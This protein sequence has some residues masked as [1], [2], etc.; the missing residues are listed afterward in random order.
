[1]DCPTNGTWTVS[2]E[3]N[4]LIYNSS[5][6]TYSITFVPQT[7]YNRVGIGRIGFLLKAKDGTGNK[8]SQDFTN[9]VGVFQVNLT[10]PLQNSTSILTSGA[11]RSITAT[12]TNGLANYVLK[13][14]GTT[15]NSATGVSSYNYN[16]TNITSNQY[17]ALEVTQGATTITKNFTVLV[18]PNT[19][20][21]T[22]PNGL[23]NGINY[24]TSD[25]TKA[26][27]E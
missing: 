26:T 5:N 6:D 23:V 21:V 9:E 15:L 19:A 3:A 8:K 17:Y 13:S 22:I 18:N 2:N 1:M 14:N 12:N 25:N 7:F 16:H 24:S 27:L 20:S 4:R 11:T 10:A